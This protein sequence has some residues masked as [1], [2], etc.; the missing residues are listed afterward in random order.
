[1]S[2]LSARPKRSCYIAVTEKTVKTRQQLYMVE[3]GNL[4]KMTITYCVAGA[5]NDVSYKN[6]IHMPG[7]S[8][9]YVPKDVAVWPKWTHF[10]RRHRGDFTLQ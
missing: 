10:N 5:P 1:M 6:N 2:P 9:H 4:E 8:I 3:K 7:I